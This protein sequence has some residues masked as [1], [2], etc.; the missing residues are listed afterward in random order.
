M[1]K[2]IIEADF[3]PPAVAEI[4]D[5][6]ILDNDLSAAH[7]VGPSLN[8]ASESSAFEVSDSKASSTRTES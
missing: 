3:F 8:K 4:K 5:A 6:S 1:M 7:S 2:E